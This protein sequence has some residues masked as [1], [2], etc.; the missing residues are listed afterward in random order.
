MACRIPCMHRQHSS[1]FVAGISRK[2]I[3]VTSLYQLSSQAGGVH[4]AR[5]RR[6]RGSLLRPRAAREL[7]PMPSGGLSTEL[8]RGSLGVGPATVAGDRESTPLLAKPQ[9][10]AVDKHHREL[11]PETLCSFPVSAAGSARV[12]LTTGQGQAAGEA[13]S[14]CIVYLVGVAV[15]TWAVRW[16]GGNVK[17]LLVLRHVGSVARNKKEQKQIG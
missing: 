3:A 4:A 13:A 1:A 12:R 9:D 14:L 10:L 16:S 6:V 5:S 2:T 11:L 7:A 17:L 15:V 8:W